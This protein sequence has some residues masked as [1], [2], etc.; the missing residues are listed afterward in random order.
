MPRAFSSLI[1]VRGVILLLPDII[2]LR[3]VGEISIFPA[4]SFLVR[5]LYSISSPITMPGWKRLVGVISLA[6]FMSVIICLFCLRS[7]LSC[8]TNLLKLPYKKQNPTGA[9]L[10]FA[11][12]KRNIKRLLRFRNANGFLK[13]RLAYFQEVESVS[14]VVA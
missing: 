2:S 14:N 6:V 8:F 3:T 5:F 9:L 1:A 11:F 10:G 12:D 7:E 13:A 4:T